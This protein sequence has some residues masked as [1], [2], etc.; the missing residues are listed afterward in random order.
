M[1]DMSVLISICLS[2]YVIFVV[3]SLL[4]TPYVYLVKAYRA[5]KADRRSSEKA[6][7]QIEMEQ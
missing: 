3:T 1:Y 5:K 7:N 2:S 6:E 4:D